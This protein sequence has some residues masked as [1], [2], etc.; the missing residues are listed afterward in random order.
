MSMA[1]PNPPRRDRNGTASRPRSGQFA[2]SPVLGLRLPMWRSKLVVFLMFAAFVALAVRAA[3]IQGPGNQFY[4]A[5][6]KKRFQRTLELP[7]T[8]GKILDRNGLV[9]ATS[10]P[11]KAI[12]AVPEDVPNQ[13]EAAKIR[14]LARLLGMSEKELGKKLSED[15]GFVYLKRQVLPDVADKIAAL[16]IEGIHQ[17]REYK[18]FYPEGE[19]MAHIV[20]F[21]NVEDR[22]QEGVELARESGLAGRAGARQVIKDRLGR[23]VED[24]G[25][26]K[27]PRDGEDI[28]LS[29]DAKIQ[30]LAYNEL[31]AVVDKHKAKAASAVVLDAQTGEVLALA[32]WPTYNPND[33]TRLSGEQL[34][35]RVLTDT[36]EP[37]SMM[38]P[39]TVA[40]ALQLKRVSPSTV[41]ATTGKYN[42]EGATITDTHNYGALTVTGVIQKSSNIG[43]TKIAMMMKPQ[44][45]WD[46]Y[47]SIGLGQAPKIGFP[48]AVA[49]RVRPYKS[50]RPIEQATMSYGYGLSVSLFQMAHAYTIFAHDGELIP[51][52]MFRTNGPATGERILSPQVARDVRAMMETVTAPGGTAPEA[53]VMGYRVGGKT[54]TAYKHEGRGYNRSKYR[55]S[56]IGLAPM[57]NPRIIVAVS[58]DEPTAGSHYGGL[59]AGPAFA[60]ITGGTLR[61]LNVQPDSPIR[62]LVVSDKVQESE[63]WSSTQ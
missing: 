36:F 12:W 33:R 48:G 37:G 40:L 32:N 58:V 10:L 56:F 52:T 3:W 61:A 13:V 2:A 54:G 55:A 45:M 7:A 47:T 18:R 60:A 17:T 42:F 8:R 46:M 23:V 29:I 26:L 16:K 62:Q 38:K 22:G 51:V 27:T 9:L 57:S 53:Q 21:T 20:G 24:I 14:Q 25:V 59:V 15:K 30:Y 63:P 35:N 34:R 11:V 39:I 50:W 5:E 41:I 6:G 43:T 44:E 1:R 49:G 4:E 19:A 31:K 28:Q